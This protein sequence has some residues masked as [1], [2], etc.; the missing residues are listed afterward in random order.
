MRGVT[1]L[2]IGLFTVVIFA[3]FAI[4]L[5]VSE[6][7]WFGYAV[8]G[9]AIFRLVVWIRQLRRYRAWRAEE[10]DDQGPP[11]VG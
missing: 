2:L 8:L 7:Y 1:S 6:R 11:E 4:S 3:G 10:E 9:L 5:L